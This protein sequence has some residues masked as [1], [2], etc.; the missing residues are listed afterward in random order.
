MSRRGFTIVEVAVAAGVFSLVLYIIMAAT[1]LFKTTFLSDQLSQATQNAL[2]LASWFEEDLRQAVRDPLTGK[3]MEVDSTGAPAL[4]FYRASFTPGQYAIS[5]VPVKWALEEDQA[6]H[7]ATLVRTAFDAKGS[8]ETKRFGFAPLPM[9]GFPGNAPDANPFGL[10]VEGDT[11][12]PLQTVLITVLA[13]AQYTSGAG[14]GQD[15]ITV[16]V[17]AAVPPVS[18]HLP[19]LFQPLKKLADLP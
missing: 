5:V 12:G 18:L 7:T 10:R 15:R 11:A 13:R 14:A 17:T 16:Q 3:A 4:R 6:T 19:R 8:L 1:N 2:V 9:P